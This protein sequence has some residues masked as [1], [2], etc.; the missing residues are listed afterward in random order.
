MDTKL[1]GETRGLS[2]WA[3]VVFGRDVYFDEQGRCHMSETWHTFLKALSSPFGEVHYV[4][5]SRPISDARTAGDLTRID[6]RI[7]LHNDMAWFGS[8]SLLEK[9]RNLVSNA[10]VDIERDQVVTY[11]LLP[12]TND[13]ILSLFA[14][15]LGD[16]NVLYYGADA[17]VAAKALKNGPVLNGVQRVGYTAMQWLTTAR[18]DLTFVRDPR[19]LHDGD[20]TVRFSRPITGME[21]T[22]MSTSSTN[23]IRGSGPVTL[24]FVG[25]FRKAKGLEYLIRGFKIINNRMDV[26]LRLSMVGDGAIQGSLESL[27]ADLGIREQIQFTGYI[28][29]TEQLRRQF[30]GSDIFVLPSISEGFPR[31]LNEALAAGLPIVTTRV[32]GIP[33]VLEDERDALLVQER[34]EQELA[35]AIERVIID[36]GLRER[37]IRHGRE[38]SEELNGDP[39]QQHMDAVRKLIEAD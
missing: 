36:D 12:G 23:G 14:L 16:V 13:F 25:K 17:R 27:A 5:R 11:S 37:L 21:L 22:G 34:S 2:K 15:S 7:T 20:S 39:V 33:A 6:D 26:E 24:L 38:R 8:G 4:C 10:R 35:D 19:M 9:T 30:Q 31:V 29:D 18:A 28:S 32:G 1:E 3:F